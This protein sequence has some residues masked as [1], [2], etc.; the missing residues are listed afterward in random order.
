MNRFPSEELFLAWAAGFFDG[1]GW[2]GAMVNARANVR[3]K[4]PDIVLHVRVVQT[5]T[6]CLELLQKRF[7]GSI[8]T[9]KRKN[10]AAVLYTW[11]LANW[12]A[13]IFL[14]AVYPYTVVKRKQVELALTYPIGPR[15][16]SRLSQ[17]MAERR[18]H[19]MNQL[20]VL[21][22]EAKTYA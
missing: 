20:R 17:E 3:R 13:M 19:I 7:G 6:E 14:N 8:G 15:R 22:A 9:Y 1:E 21:R 2:V 18:M 10:T 12:S 16:I 4:R 5:S 11:R